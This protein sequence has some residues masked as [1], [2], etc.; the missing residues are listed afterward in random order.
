MH[1]YNPATTFNITMTSQWARRRLKSPI[2][3]LFTQPFIQGADQRKLQSSASLA[4][5]RGNHWWL[6]NFPHKRPVTREKFPFDDVIMV[7]SH[8]C[9]VFFSLWT[10]TFPISRHAWT[11]FNIW[12]KKHTSHWSFMNRCALIPPLELELWIGIYNP[13]TTVPVITYTSKRKL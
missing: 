3:R 8:Q 4:F 9:F 5:V 12:N 10:N 13:Q 7:V 2:S 6:V 11:L 1:L